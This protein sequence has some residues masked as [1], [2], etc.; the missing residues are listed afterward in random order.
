MRVMID[1]NILISAVVFPNDRI[2]AV[3]IKAATEHKL[4]ISAQIIEELYHVVARKFSGKAAAVDDFLTKL[5]FE[6]VYATRQPQPGLFVIR[7]EKDYP[8][9]YTAIMEGADVFITG[10]KDFQGINMDKPEIVTPSEFLE[11]Y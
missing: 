10:D 9:L 7:D 4:L 5:P 6:Y 8:I 2:N 3:I 11:R 1:T